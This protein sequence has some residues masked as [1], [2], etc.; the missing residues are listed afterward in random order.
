M[1]DIE[2]IK[3]EIERRLEEIEN[4]IRIGNKKIQKSGGNRMAELVKVLAFI[5]SLPAA[6]PELEDEIKRYQQED[7]D[8]DTTIRDVAH[9]FV[10]WQKAQMENTVEEYKSLPKMHV[11]ITR[12]KNGFL[13][14]YPKTP[15]YN[16]KYGVW[17]CGEFS[18]KLDPKLFPELTEESEPI[19]VDLLIRK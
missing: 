11:W 1:T 15:S 10:N 18:I 13:G 2:I 9:H 6:S 8:R 4:T 14:G 19:E 16:V 3:S 12:N 5:D 17:E 7:C